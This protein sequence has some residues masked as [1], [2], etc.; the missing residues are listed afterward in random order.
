MKRVFVYVMAIIFALNMSAQTIVY[1]STNAGVVNSSFID[2][3]YNEEWQDVEPYVLK[4]TTTAF[5]NQGKEKYDIRLFKFKNWEEEPGDFNV[6]QISSKLQPAFVQMD[7]D[8]WNYFYTEKD[9]ADSSLPF[10]TIEMEN[11]CT[12]VLFSGITI[13][14]TPPFL[15]VYALKDGKATL[16]FNKHAY[17]NDLVALNGIVDFHLQMNTL[18]YETLESTAPV[19]PA[20]IHHLIFENGRIS[21]K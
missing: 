4:K 13:D 20:D 19:K 2:S 15:T 14:S 5:S 8:G 7:G 3:F 11:G 1:D 12:F 10:Y 16:V 9:T 17:I 21:Y 6:I 18:E